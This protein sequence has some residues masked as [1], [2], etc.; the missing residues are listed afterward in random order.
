M[1]KAK[2]DCGGILNLCRTPRKFASENTGAALWKLVAT[3]R[4]PT[5]YTSAGRPEGMRSAPS[6]ERRIRRT[7]P[8]L[9]PSKAKAFRGGLG[10][11]MRSDCGDDGYDEDEREPPDPVGEGG[12]ALTD[13][14]G[15]DL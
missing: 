10:P 9:E 6:C 13:M 14:N 1:A 8:R 4:R 5:P 7:S 15:S 3:D 11:N 12:S 2:K